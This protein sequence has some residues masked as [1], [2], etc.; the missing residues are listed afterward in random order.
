MTTPDPQR[1][2][3]ATNLLTEAQ[4]VFGAPLARVI[5]SGAWS[6]QQEVWIGVREWLSRAA[7]DRLQSALSIASL[8]LEVEA[9]DT[10]RAW[11]VGKNPVLGDRAPAIV[12]AEDPERVRRAARDFVAYG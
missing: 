8:L 1:W 11:F 7:T 12:L 10:V 4:L 5:A 3:P 9:Q 2:A 6:E